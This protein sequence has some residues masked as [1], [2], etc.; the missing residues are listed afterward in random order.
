ML[1]SAFFNWVVNDSNNYCMWNPGKRSIRWHS[2]AHL[3]TA[4]H[5]YYTYV[6]QC[7]VICD[8]LFS[9]SPTD[10]GA[11]F[12]TL[13]FDICEPQQCTDIT[14]I[15]DTV[16]ESIE[17]FFINLQRTPDLDPRIT[18]DPMIGEIEITNNNGLW[19]FWCNWT[20]WMTLRCSLALWHSLDLFYSRTIC[21]RICE[22]STHC[23]GEWRPGGGVCQSHSHS[24]TYSQQN[25]SCE[26]VQWW[27]LCVHP[28]WCCES[29]YVGTHL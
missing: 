3:H 2:A 10:Y 7:M 25:S 15:N 16:P 22:D 4:K 23:Y 19:I 11:M 18:L 14:I 29:K 20:H 27:E 1:S 9:V 8:F 28:T 21:C 6:V 24:Y 17:S 26:R 13:M 5:A 12:T